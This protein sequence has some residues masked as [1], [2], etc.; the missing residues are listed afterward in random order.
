MKSEVGNGMEW[1]VLVP[2]LVSG[3]FHFS[4]TDPPVTSGTDL[5]NQPCT[6]VGL[7]ERTPGFTS[8]PLG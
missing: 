4:E 1:L 5:V 7:A 2:Q 8:V 3:G 6:S